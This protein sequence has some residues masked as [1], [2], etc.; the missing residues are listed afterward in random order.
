METNLVRIISDV[1][2]IMEIE[3]TFKKVIHVSGELKKSWVKERGGV[4]VPVESASHFDEHDAELISKA[5]QA[6]GLRKCFGVAAEPLEGVP[7]LVE[8]RITKQGLLEFNRDFCHFNFALIGEFFEFIILCTTNDYYL[9]SGK[10]GFVEEAIGMTIEEGFRQF[11]MFVM[12]SNLSTG[13]KNRLL[14][15]LENCK[16]ADSVFPIGKCD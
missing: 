16:N 11:Q 13:E 9:V 14:N 10:R 4:V 2:K 5:I 1:S 7:K 3:E 15:I 12:A 6:T 8:I